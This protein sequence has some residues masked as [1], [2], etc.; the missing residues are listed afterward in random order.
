[1][2][3]S[4]DG[5][6][7][8]RSRSGNN[9]SV[10]R[11]S[12]RDKDKERRSSS[13]SSGRS[14]HSRGHKDMRLSDMSTKSLE[15]KIGDILSKQ[16]PKALQS[17]VHDEVAAAVNPITKAIPQLFN[18]LDS[19]SNNL[20]SLSISCEQRFTE[21]GNNTK[22]LSSRMDVLEG[23]IETFEQGYSGANEGNGSAGSGS[24]LPLPPSQVETQSDSWSRTPDPTII[25][26]STEERKK[27]SKSSAQAAMEELANIAGVPPTCFSVEGGDLANFYTAKFEGIKCVAA[28]AV[29]KMLKPYKTPEGNFRNFTGKDVDEGDVKL[30]IN[31]DKNGKLQKTEG[32]TRRL[33]KCIRDK[34]PDLNLF[35]RRSEGAVSCSFKKLAQ[36]KVTRDE[37]SV[38]WN[39]KTVQLFGVEKDS[40]SKSFMEEEN[41][42]WCS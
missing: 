1:M 24:Q 4:H 5:K 36:L 37:V 40:I 34:H 41:I 14:N 20:Q 2:P 21:L 26:I 9:R 38:E 19:L 32:A 12:K 10:A 42:Q 30:F 25:K 6:S 16:L 23:R 3:A 22:N 7:S 35:G 8:K 18:G 15:D 27:I 39:P 28:A 13:S 31:P 29:T 33:V 11:K 17:T